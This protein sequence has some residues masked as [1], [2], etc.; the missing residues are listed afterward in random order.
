MLK[1]STLNDKS[2]LD[3]FLNLANLIP[4]SEAFH[5]VIASQ[6]VNIQQA[7]KS[8]KNEIIKSCISDKIFYVNEVT[9]FHA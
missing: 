8:N 2:L 3:L 1:Q 6:P 4:S 5:E 9:V 7:I